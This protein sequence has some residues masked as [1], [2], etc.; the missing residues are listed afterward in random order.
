[1]VWSTR[2]SLFSLETVQVW[3]QPL[4]LLALVP[5]PPKTLLLMTRVL[6][7]S[8]KTPVALVLVMY[9]LTP[10][11]VLLLMT[12]M[13][14]LSLKTLVPTLKAR[15][16]VMPVPLLLPL[17]FVP[18]FPKTLILMTCMLLSSLE[19]SETSVP[20][21]S[22][23]LL[24]QVILLMMFVPIFSRKTLM[25]LYMARTHVTPVPLFP[26]MM[27]VLVLEGRWPSVLQ[28]VR[29][30]VCMVLVG[31]LLMPLQTP[32]HLLV[33]VESP[34]L[35]FLWPRRPEPKRRRK[36]RSRPGSWPTN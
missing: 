21:K 36:Q 7:F 30:V 6:I 4:P 5:I 1:M 20:M 26:L 16:P 15:T 33:A 3:L 14:I 22:L 12:Y 23:M 31:I 9:V 34:P 32:I 2:S 29:A 19:A 13:L 8:L 28:L 17:T 27:S 24:T 25:Q 35:G 18:N 10:S 11:K